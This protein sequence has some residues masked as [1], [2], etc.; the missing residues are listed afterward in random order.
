MRSDSSTDFFKGYNGSYISLDIATIKC[1]SFLQELQ[2]A[3]RNEVK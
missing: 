1:K 2:E 3:S